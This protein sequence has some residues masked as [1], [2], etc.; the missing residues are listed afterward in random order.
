MVAAIEDHARVT[1]PEECCGFLIGLPGEP[2]R[3]IETMRAKNVA[4]V[5]R[6]RRYEIDPLE[7][8]HADDAA[9]TKRADLIGIYH[10]HPNHPAKPSEFDRSRA[11]SWYTYVI[12][13]IVDETPKE[14]TAW[15]F[16]DTTKSFL[17]EELRVSL[18]PSGRTLSRTPSSVRRGH[19][20]S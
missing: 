13:A 1:F 14:L 2:R 11:T 7:L 4:A 18:R 12:L 6:N 17:S 9:R 10:S 3:V 16:D 15:H 19:G 20:A 8:L 5:D